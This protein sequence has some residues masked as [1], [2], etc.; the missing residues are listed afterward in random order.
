MNDVN[1]SGLTAFGGSIP[2]KLAASGMDISALRSYEGQIVNGI[3]VNALLRKD[4]WI[5]LDNAVVD[6]ARAQLNGIADLRTA[7]LVQNLGGLGTLISEYEKLQD[8]GD[9]DVSMSGVTTGDR[10]T[11]GFAVAGVP[12]FIT[13]KDFQLNIRRLL[14]S[15]NTGQGLDTTQVAV[16]TRKVADKLENILFNGLSLTVD[17]YPVY[18][19]TT[20]PD[21]NTGTAAGDFGTITNIYPTI[22]NMVTAAEADNYFGPYTLYVARTQYGEMRQIYSDGSGQTAIQRC[23]DGIPALTAIKPSSVLADGSLVLVT[24]QRDVVDLAI[25]QDIAVVEWDTM[26]GMVSNFKVMTAQVPRIKSDS[27][28]R[29]GIVYFTGA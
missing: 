2:A 29:S 17:G 27:A 18:G 6:V 8:M 28:G 10:D 7:N 15:R 24:M 25:A 12:V 16:A 23:L 5:E 19:Y 20:H 11:V 4:E 3:R 13:H 26:G 1:I 14:A 9:A 22:N 21:V